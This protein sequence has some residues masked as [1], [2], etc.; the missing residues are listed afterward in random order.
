MLHNTS[1]GPF[2]TLFCANLPSRLRSLDRKMKKEKISPISNCFRATIARE[3]SFHKRNASL[4]LIGS[5][6]CTSY[7]FVVHC[8]GGEERS[9]VCKVRVICINVRQFNGD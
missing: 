3:Q 6:D 5:L 1:T 9:T 2:T 7:L 4:L 8:N